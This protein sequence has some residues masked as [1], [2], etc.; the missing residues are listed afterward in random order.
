MISY[1]RH[2]LALRSLIV[3]SIN[4]K[5][6]IENK[7]KNSAIHGVTRFY[8]GSRLLGRLRR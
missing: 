3:A 4:R 8:H 5:K 6:E 7:N 1:P 2:E